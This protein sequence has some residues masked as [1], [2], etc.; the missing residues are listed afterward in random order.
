[1]TPSLTPRVRRGR[2]GHWCLVM[3][4]TNSS[5]DRRPVSW[6]T[7]VSPPLKNST[8]GIV[9]TS[10]LT[11]MLGFSSTFSLPTFTLPANWSATWSMTGESRRHGPHHG[12]QKSATTRVP[13]VT[14]SFQLAS[15]SS[16]T[17]GLAMRESLWFVVCR[18][19]P[20]T[21]GTSPT[22]YAPGDTAPACG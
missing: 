18:R 21:A 20:A 15:V 4:W 17:F 7:G 19:S 10:Y 6:W 5:A 3:S 22:F 9:I 14:Y 11:A 1:P 16:I 2:F 8:R 12:A 13:L